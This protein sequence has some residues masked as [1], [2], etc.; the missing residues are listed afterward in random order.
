MEFQDYSW[1]A[2]LYEKFGVPHPKLSFGIACLIGGIVFTGVWWM[3]GADYRRQEAIQNRASNFN[4]RLDAL[5]RRIDALPAIQ[6][7]DVK[8]RE[9]EE[10]VRKVVNFP[11][12]VNDVAAPKTIVESLAADQ[13]PL[14]LF[15]T[16]IRYDQDVLKSVPNSGPMLHDFVERYYKFQT[17]EG[18]LESELLGHIGRMVRVRFTAGWQIYL[19]Y[20]LLRF[21][22]L[23]K[24]QIISQG[25]FLNYDITWDD[26][27]RL[28][29]QISSDHDTVE[30]VKH[31]F[32]EYNGFGEQIKKL[33]V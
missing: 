12:A 1:L 24:D 31:L 10:S 16:L 7:D 8:H 5:S 9:I 13:S 20:T 30:K 19:R 4:E 18:Q 15:D 14:I 11:N 21:S 25:T 27:E 26:A 22:G 33:K 23:S 32:S 2:T 28:Y 3:V 6:P 17:D 29:T